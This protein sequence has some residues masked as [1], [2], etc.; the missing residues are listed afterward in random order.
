MKTNQ[1]LQTDVQNAIKWEPL[2]NAAEIGVTVKD[3]VVT[4]TGVVDSYSKKMEAEAAA[5]NV[6]GVK[7]VVEKIEIKYSNTW[8]KKDDNEVAN[9]VLNAFKWNWQVPNDKIK[10][11]VEKGWVTLEGELNWNYQREAAKDA[12]RNLLGVTG[13]TNNI[14]IKSETHDAIEKMD[15]ENALTRNW[16]VS[17]Q[18]IRVKVDGSKVTLEGIVNSPY[19]KEEAERIAWNAPGVWN[20]DNLLAIEYALSLID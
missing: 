8:S 5:K 6:V 12:V 9:E 16:S 19:Q 20:V 13:V 7:A 10:I 17:D 4:L 3:G 2:M 15:I 14:K 1:E 18:D 11:K